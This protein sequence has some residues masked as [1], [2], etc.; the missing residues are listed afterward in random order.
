MCDRSGAYTVVVKVATTVRGTTDANKRN[1]KQ[2]QKIM[3]HLGHAYQKL[4]KYIRRE[5]RR[6]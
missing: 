4:V 3:P 5:C 6:F 2:T 1:K